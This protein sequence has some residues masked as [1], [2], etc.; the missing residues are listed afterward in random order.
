M[1]TKVSVN[2]K[3]IVAEKKQTMFELMDS[4][5]EI[6][7]VG[8][9]FIYLQVGD[10]DNRIVFTTI[11]YVTDPKTKKVLVSAD[12][13][14]GEYDFSYLVLSKEGFSAYKTGHDKVRDP[15]PF[16]D[17]YKLEIPGKGLLERFHEHLMLQKRE[18]NTS[19]TVARYKDETGL[20]IQ[21]GE[22]VLSAHYISPK[23]A[24]EGL[25]EVNDVV[26]KKVQEKKDNDIQT[27]KIAASFKEE[28]VKK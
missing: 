26:D 23:E 16:Q 10:G 2:D 14:P 3:D 24:E 22:D 1:L 8:K 17:P 19:N 6:P 20:H 15:K 21:I 9:R 7:Q 18:N 4:L 28:T 13:Q 12:L 5:I 11:P 27:A 25:K